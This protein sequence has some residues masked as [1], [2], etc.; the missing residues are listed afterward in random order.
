MDFEGLLSIVCDIMGWH[1]ARLRCQ[2]SGLAFF[3]YLQDLVQELKS[4]L[5]GHF[6]DVIVALMM[7]PTE[8]DA[9]ELRQALKVSKI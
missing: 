2:P 4:A 5:S 9:Y 7:T 6:E 8:Y 3:C 1:L